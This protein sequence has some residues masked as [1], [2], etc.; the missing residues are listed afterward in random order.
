MCDPVLGGI[1]WAEA[2]AVKPS[3]MRQGISYDFWSSYRSNASLNA[4]IYPEVAIVRA[5]AAL[6]R[7]FLNLR[8]ATQLAK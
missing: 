3:D 6:V 8:S 7:D 4:G 1:D 2:I 5:R